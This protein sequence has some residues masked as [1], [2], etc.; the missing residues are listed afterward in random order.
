MSTSPRTR[1]KASPVLRSRRI[2]R[3]G[4]TLPPSRV[5]FGPTVVKGVALSQSD[6]RVIDAHDRM[7]TGGVHEVGVDQLFFSTTNALGIIEQANSVFSQISRFSHEELVGKPHNLIRHPDMPQGAFR[8]MW[9]T[10]QAG[11]PFCAYVVNLAKD[12]SDYLVFATVT[13]LGDGY[14][15]VRS[16]P[17]VI[18]LRDAVLGIYRAV[19]PGEIELRFSGMNTREVARVGADNLLAQ[20][21]AAGFAT[22]EEFVWTALPAE[23]QARTAASGP[24]ERHPC[25]GPLAALQATAA[26]V[27]EELDEW[28]SRMD[29]LQS[30][31]EALGAEVPRIRAAIDESG[32]TATSVSERLGGHTG[33]APIMLSVNLW[34]SMTTD[35]V[36]ILD[37]LVE[38]L[39][40]L[41]ASAARTRFRIALARLH[42][43]AVVQ[44]IEEL[45][46]S[47]PGTQDARPAIVDLTRALQEGVVETELQMKANAENAQRVAGKLE[48]AHGLLLMPHGLIANWSQMVVGRQD[49][50]VLQLLPV[51]ENQMEISNDNLAR[52]A[53]LAETSR[54][55]AQ[56]VNATGMRQQCRSMRE[57]AAELAAPRSAGVRSEPETPAPTLDPRRLA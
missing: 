5:T 43:D 6:I 31:V 45:A 53:R 42:N 32:R 57:A 8:L 13:P 38:E 28:M 4:G 34:A 49:D 35:I 14:L 9:E 41:R 25:H 29:A 2:T 21:Q 12:G 15:S 1:T 47:R 50:E 16:R 37:D 55:I 18:E 46:T 30:A 23:V 36:T 3:L 7:P 39:V 17:C 11:Q 26:V 52:L 40:G 56:P 33:M 48:S 20:V 10:L 44:S 54:S 24:A 27:S 22:F 51:I 19:R